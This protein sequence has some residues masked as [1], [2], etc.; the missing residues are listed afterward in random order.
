MWPSVTALW[1][2]SLSGRTEEASQDWARL[3]PYCVVFEKRGAVNIRYP[4]TPFTL[5]RLEWVIIRRLSTPLLY[6]VKQLSKNGDVVAQWSS[7]LCM[8][9]LLCYL[10][11][12]QV[13]QICISVASIRHMFGF[14][15]AREGCTWCRWL[16]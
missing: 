7:Q 14:C 1:L 6:A 13:T 8:H 5:V 16:L 11:C 9:I 4:F 15:G 12:I 10:N 3:R 2:S